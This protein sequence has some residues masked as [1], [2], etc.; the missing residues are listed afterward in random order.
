M[1]RKW[2]PKEK[3]EIVLEGLKDESGISA[4]CRSKTISTT[5]F[6]KWKQQLLGSAEAI[7]HSPNNKPSIK[8]EQ[9]RQENQR[10]KSVIAEVIAE[11]LE[12]K[13]GSMD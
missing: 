13:K 10:M 5:Q 7:Y 3:L 2:S 12:L 6:Y 1:H 8:E 11:N 9:L 4:I